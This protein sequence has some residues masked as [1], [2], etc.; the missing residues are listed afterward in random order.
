MEP[1][2]HHTI[3]KQIYTTITPFKKKQTKKTSNESPSAI[4]N[5]P[6]IYR[7][8]RL[9]KKKTPKARSKPN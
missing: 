5:E 4:S 9:T 3:R 6:E 2:T 8:Q 7:L 1:E